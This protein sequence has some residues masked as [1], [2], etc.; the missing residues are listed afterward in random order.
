MTFDADVAVVGA[1]ILGLATAVEF[2]RRD[3]ARQV[4]VL[5]KEADVAVHQTGRN[6]C[7][8]HSGVY[9]A[10]G[11]QKAELCV[12]GR[13]L[14]LR[15]CDEAAIPYEICGKVIVAVEERE[16]PRLDELERRARA[17]GVVARRIGT[18][19]L[20]DLEPHVVGLDALHL[21][22]AGL[23][24]FAHVARA[25]AAHL[26]AG[27]GEIRLRTQVRSITE[28]D[29][30]V[31]IVTSSGDVLSAR[32]AVVC[33]GLQAD[34][35]VPSN[36]GELP[37]LV[38][39]RGSYFAL[40]PEARHLC[41]G[42]IYPVPD[43]RFPFLGVHLSRRPDGEVWAGPNAVLALAREG[44]RRSEIDARDAWEALTAAPFW[45][46]A[47]RYWKTG[48]AEVYR[49]LVPRA[50]AAAVSRYVP[51]ISRRDLVRAPS[52]IRPQA[53]TKQGRLADDFV[54]VELGRILHVLN[55]PSPAAT[56]SLA[57]A[58]HIVERAML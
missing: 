40:R 31:R 53:L 4:V 3:P 41:R 24:D 14:L 19:E 32:Q 39:F 27:R 43:P 22:E 18:T 44:Y 5:E 54:F 37:Q 25:L 52:G 50:F 38:P 45:M 30:H 1:G 7:V 16:L 55:A 33:A 17:N 51:E 10:P 15:F 49:D 48:A 47:R 2:A 36:G 12:R 8:I 46:L 11:S 58:Q 6:S 29:N 28:R 42:L 20:L 34:R 23:V 13:D 35:L 9:Y 57:I 21:P 26:T 56:S